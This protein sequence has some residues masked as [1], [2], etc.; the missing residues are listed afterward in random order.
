[1]SH[2]FFDLDKT[3]IRTQSQG[4]LIQVLY[5]RKIIS[6]VTVLKLHFFFLRYKLHLIGE[7][8][9]PKLYKESAKLFKGV[10]VEYMKKVVRAFVF[11]EFASIQNF[12]AVEELEKHIS[13][14][15]HVVLTSAAFEPIVEAA[16]KFFHIPQYTSTQLKVEDG[17][18]TGEILGIPNY[19][20]NKITNLQKY[21]FEGSFAY[22]DH[23]SD[24]PLMIKATY[25]YAVSPTKKL[26][27]YA[28]SHGWFILE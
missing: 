20:E 23:H 10:D 12:R 24:I 26:R 11:A 17:K 22:S 13:A 18:Y 3:L 6:L 8:S 14:G 21:D 2:V 1:M 25:R 19:G 4:L 9:M 27:D 28:K 5:K 15:K 7:D 16:A